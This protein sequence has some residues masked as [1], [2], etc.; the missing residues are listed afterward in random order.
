MEAFLAQR[1]A[2]F[3]VLMADPMQWVAVAAGVAG[4]GLVIASSLART[5]LPLRWLAAAS[6]VGFIVYGLVH[7]APLVFGLHLALLPINLW[8][9]VEM[10]RL[11]RRVLAAQAGQGLQVWLQPYMKRR[12]LRDGEVLFREGDPAD[13]LYV[14]AEGALEFL[15][16]GKRIGPGE[17]VGEISFFSPQGRRTGTLRAAGPA[18]LLS[19]DEV[20]MRHL[21]HENPAFGFEIVRLVAARL[22]SDVARWRAAAEAGRDRIG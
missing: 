11:T 14:V 21:F 5:I 1:L 19:M 22:S 10:Q 4:G 20:A 8:R 13:R 7:P 18:T 2:D 9:A 15:P 16:G 12:R 6:N 3:Q 17:M